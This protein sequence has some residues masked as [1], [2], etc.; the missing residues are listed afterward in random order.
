MIN[1]AL[2]DQE[3]TDLTGAVARHQRTINELLAQAPNPSRVGL[4]GEIL[5]EQ[6]R[7]YDALLLKLEGEP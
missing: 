1:I 7:R 6:V 3:V 2:T 5:T 4:V